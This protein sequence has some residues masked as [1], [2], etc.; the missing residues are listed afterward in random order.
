MDIKEQIKKTFED[1]VYRTKFTSKEINE[2]V[3]KKFG[4]DKQSVLPSDRCYNK[5][6]KGLTFDKELHIFEDL[7]DEDKYMYLGEGNKYNGKIFFN[8]VNSH[9]EQEVGEWIDGKSKFYINTV[10]AIWV[11]AA[12]L[13][14]ERYNN[15]ENPGPD[16]IFFYQSDIVERAKDIHGA[17]VQ[18]TL[19]STQAVANFKDTNYN[20]LVSGINDLEKYR[21]VTYNMEFDGDKEKPDINKDLM[22]ESNLGEISIE[23]LINFVNKEYTEMFTN[24]E[25]DTLLTT[26]KCISILEYLDKYA[27]KPY[28]GPEKSKPEEKAVLNEMKE[29]GGA[30][31]KELDK[32]ARLCEI[33]FGLKKVGTSK[34]LDG[35]NTKIRE[36]LW[37]Q[38]KLPGYE[39]CLTS[40][41]LFVEIAEGDKARFRFSVELNEAQSEQ[42]DYDKH[43]RILKRDITAGHNLVYLLSGNDFMKQIKESTHDVKAN[44]D[45]GTYK[46]IQVSFIITQED[47]GIKY[48]NDY[49][50]LNGML[51]AI[52]ELMPYYKLVIEEGNMG[53]ESEK[54][55]VVLDK[56]IEEKS[57]IDLNIIL[58]GPPGTGKTYN[59]VNYAVAII[60]NVSVDMIQEEDYKEV[61]QRYI[62]YKENE[63]IVF[64]TFHQSYG[65]EEFIEGIKPQLKRVDDNDDSIDLSYTMAD[66]IFKKFCNKAKQVKIKNASIGIREEPMIWNVLLDG[67]GMSELKRKCFDNNYIRIGWTDSDEIITD[68]TVD[69]SDKAKRILLNFQDE[70]QEGDIVLIQRDNTSID[71]IGIITGLYEFIESEEEYPRS[72]TV[73]W[74]VTDINENVYEMNKQTKLDRKSVYPLSKMDIKDVIALVDKYADGNQITVEENQESYVFIIDEINRGNISKIFGEL[75]TLIEDTKRIGKDEAM[76]AKLPYSGKPFGVPNN[77]YIIGTMNTADRSIA[78]M[79]TALRRRFQFIEM[80]PNSNVLINIPEIDGISIAKMLDTINERIEFLFDREHTIGHAY[81]TCLSEEPTIEKLARIFK[82]S[83]IPLLQEYFYEDYSKIQLV[84]GDNAKENKYKFILDTDMKSK[85]IF[86]GNPDID[87]LPEKK[88]SIQNSSFNEAESYKQIY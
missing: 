8:G 70:M 14:Y 78:L 79:D 53:A 56:L 23:T 85:Y 66:G 5:T 36:Y 59:T 30:A 13:T 1:T 34:W 15:L 27:G 76:T 16:D 40:I 84:L 24:N 88:Y 62:K 19:A 87:D 61:Q 68:Q 52:A 32:M 63:K 28:T 54:K 33:D 31:V 42:K 9:K 49:G 47:I 58:Y 39:N 41:S 18:A 82:N 37:R 69:L 51:E 2:K 29:S 38:L 73:H 60:E 20:Y 10:E 80:M 35:S 48:K 86:K 77:V 67:T 22:I 25:K 64:T 74:I 11:A 55:V 43:H 17:K 6:N 4:T 71:A 81:F 50:V 72:R 83:I 12:I 21:R 75:I 57:K 46:K 7:K 44:I 3:N 45:D 65:Y 26:T